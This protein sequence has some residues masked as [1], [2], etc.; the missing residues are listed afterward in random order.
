[1][2]PFNAKSSFWAH[3]FEPN[4]WL[5][6]KQHLFLVFG[7]LIPAIIIGI[8]LGISASYIPSARFIILNAVSIIQTI[9]SLALFVFLIP[10]FSQ[11]GTLPALIALFLYALLPI[12]RNTYTGISDIPKNLRESAIVLGLPF[13]PRLAF[14]EL[15]LASRMILAGVKTA[16]VIN[17]GTATIAALIGAGGYGE[18]IISGLALNNYAMLFSGAIPACLLAILVQLSFDILDYWLVPKGLKR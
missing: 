5:L 17:V 2:D 9:P 11:I 13:F 6:T 18:R 4:L 7:S 8:S 16:A 3:L 12:V 10:L 14:I 15:P 1:M